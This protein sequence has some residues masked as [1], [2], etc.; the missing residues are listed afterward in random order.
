MGSGY[1]RFSFP[2][3]TPGIEWVVVV[4]Q[5]EGDP[6]AFFRDRDDIRVV[7]SQETGLS[8]S[9]NLAVEA[10]RTDWMLL[11]DDDVIIDRQAVLELV[12]TA[13]DYRSRDA[14]AGFFWARLRKASGG[15]MANYPAPGTRLTRRNAR[16]VQSASLLVSK[17]A[18]D[19][20]EARFDVR[21]GLGTDLPVG[22][23][24]LLVVALMKNEWTGW[25]VAHVVGTHPD[26]TT[27]SGS[28][29]RRVLRARMAIMGHAFGW[30]APVVRARY[31]RAH[32]EKFE[33]LTEMTKFTLGSRDF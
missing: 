5:P 16:S 4:Q 32:R 23:E 19:A 17:H 20:A 15:W 30:L 10:T 26:E 25:H 18:M 31:A 14:R 21:F 11:C 1:R 6:D 7:S 33:S 13:M 24:Y 22:E 29:D 3:E 28:A 12:E 8:R 9:R 27:H 2:E